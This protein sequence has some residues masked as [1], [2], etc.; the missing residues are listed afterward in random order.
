[1]RILG[2]HVFLKTCRQWYLLLSFNFKFQTNETFPYK[3]QDKTFNF[4]EK[5][6][7]FLS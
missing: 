3:T 6:F 1:M 5:M 7:C 4:Y 2:P